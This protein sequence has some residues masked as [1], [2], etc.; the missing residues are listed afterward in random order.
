MFSR[1]RRSSSR[2]RSDDEGSESTTSRSRQSTVSTSGYQTPPPDAPHSTIPSLM[3]E[4]FDR[5][6]SLDGD[7]RY[8]SRASS[9]CKYCLLTVQATVC[10]VL[11]DK[12]QSVRVHTVQ[13]SHFIVKSNVRSFYTSD[14]E[15][16]FCIAVSSVRRL[17]RGRP[18]TVSAHS[19]Y[20]SCPISDQDHILLLFILCV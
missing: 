12:P 5:P 20:P 1:R 14:Q 10:T 13:F 16:Q 18:R 6:L 7:D 3:I 17:I 2:R 15:S 8:A 11:F 4:N 9:I 19:P